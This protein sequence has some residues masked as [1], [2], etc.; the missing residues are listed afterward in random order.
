MLGV[1]DEG[2]IGFPIGNTNIKAIIVDL[3]TA[4]TETTSSTAEWVMSE[5]IKNPKMMRKAQAEV[6]GMLDNKSPQ[7]HENHMDGLHYTRMV[8][9]E[10]MRLHPAVP[11]L[12][13]RVYRET[14]DV[15]GFEVKK[16]TRVIINSWALARSPENWPEAEEFKPERFKDS[17]ASYDKGA[18][19][20]YLPFGGGRRMCPGDVFALAVLELIVA[21]LLYYFDWSLPDGMRPDELDMDTTVGSTARRTNQLRLVASPYNIPIEN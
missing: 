12:L 8:I 2:D 7:D 9:K 16:G 21:R 15:G 19:F 20:E 14:C 13:P 6:R 17:Q 3:F 4:G 10:T 11:L 5:L 1:R 18:Q